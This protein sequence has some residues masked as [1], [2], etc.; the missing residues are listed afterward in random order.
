MRKQVEASSPRWSAPAAPA[1]SSP[2]ISTSTG[3]PRPRTSSIRKAACCA[4][5]RP[6]RNRSADRR[7][8]RPGHRQQR[9][10]RQPAD[11]QRRR[12][13]A[14]DQSKKTEETNNYEISRTTKTE[15]TEAGRVNRIS[16]AVL[17][18]GSYAK[19]DKGEMVYQDA[20]QGGARPHRRAGALGD[21]L[22]PEARRPGRGRQSA[23]RRGARRSPD[24]R[25]D[26]LARH[27]AVHQGRHHVRRSSSA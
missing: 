11:Q 18:D 13:A 7:E 27:A 10:A 24:R 1:S 20:H 22:R 6:A 8:Q 21:R 15:V 5:A 12:R 14:R 25:A 17:V 16:V 2:P 23:L 3:S 26:R 9:A 4:R 19:N